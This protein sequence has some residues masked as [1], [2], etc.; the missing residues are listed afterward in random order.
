MNPIKLIIVD[1]FQMLIDGFSALL[2]GEPEVEV[3]G[4]ALNGKELQQVL[5]QKQ[6]DLILLDIEMPEMD[7]KE[8]AKWMKKNHPEIKI[9]ILTVHQEIGYIKQLLKLGVDGYLLKDSGKEELMDAIETISSGKSYHDKRVEKIL[10]EDLAS[11]EYPNAALFQLTPREMEIV[12][13]ISEGLTSQ[14]I[15]GDLHISPQ[16]VLCHRKNILNKARQD[17][18]VPNM[19]ALVK[20]LTN[21]GMLDC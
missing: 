21:R 15:A 13:L 4:S 5:T 6:P 16:T 3:I 14:K 18:E 11:R 20:Y 10:I 9:L 19:A 7:G 12:C 8:A 17:L 2:A 1:D